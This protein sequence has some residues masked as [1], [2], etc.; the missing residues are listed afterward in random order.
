MKRFL[1]DSLADVASAMY[2]NIKCLDHNDV[3][4][5]GKYEDA[6]VV[7]KELLMYDEVF[8][9]HI[10]ITP[11][12]WDG[13]DKEYYVTLDEDMDVWCEKAYDSEH[14]SYVYD[15]TECLFI[16]DDCN[17]AILSKID[18][19][20]NTIYEVSY[21]LEDDDCY[22]CECDGN[23]ECCG[24]SEKSNDAHEVITRVATDE[25]GKLRGFEKSWETHADGLHYHSTY[26][27]YS[28]DEK[29]LKNMLDN[30]SIK[31]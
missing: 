25:D 18:C 21:D 4:F 27:F 9:H 1:I 7:I 8:P 23:C 30:F 31:Y 3:M 20:E 11:E 16:A 29:M 10:K 13:Y 2:E 26:S 5:V 22:D 28:S 24:L 17:S 6:I 15:E 12:F 14:A 19:N